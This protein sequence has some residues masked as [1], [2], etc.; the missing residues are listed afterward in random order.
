VQYAAL[1]DYDKDRNHKID[2]QERMLAYEHMDI[3]DNPIIRW[4]M[5]NPD[6]I[7]ASMG[8]NP[9]TPKNIPSAGKGTSFNW[10]A[11]IGASYN[12]NNQFNTQKNFPQAT[13]EG[14]FVFPDYMNLGQVSQTG[15]S[16]NIPEIITSDNNGNETTKSLNETMPFHL[17]G[18]SPTKDQLIIGVDG[19]SSDYTYDK[20]DILVVPASRFD[21]LLKKKPFG[22]FRGQQ[23]TIQS[24]GNPVITDFSNVFNKPK[25]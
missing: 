13:T 16:Q 14:K 12:R 17:I 8:A 3:K 11:T 1:K 25:K 19:K 20:G 15:E 21:D 7:S 6:Y 9:S 22:I 5:S 18:Y 4:A 23:V 10:N 2:P 24:K